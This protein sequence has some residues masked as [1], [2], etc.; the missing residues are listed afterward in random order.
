[1]HIKYGGKYLTVVQ[2]GKLPTKE[3]STFWYLHS[4]IHTQNTQSRQCKGEGTTVVLL[5]WIN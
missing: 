4:I 2:K 3:S 1:M 5:K